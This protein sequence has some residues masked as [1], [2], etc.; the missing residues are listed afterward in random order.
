MGFH[1]RVIAGA[2]ALCFV[3][4]GPA[5]AQL[6]DLGTL[7]G[8]TSQA[9]GVRADGALVVGSSLNASS[10]TQAFVYSVNA[11]FTGGTMTALNFLAGGTAAEARAVNS[12]GLV[13]GYSRDAGSVEQA[14][15]W[16]GTNVAL[17]TNNLGGSGA[18]AFGVSA[19]GDVVGWAR[20]ATGGVQRAFVSVGGGA[21]SALNLS[22]ING[23]HDPSVGHNARA[24]GISPNGRFVV[25]E[26]EV[27]NGSGGIEVR[28][29]VYDQTVPTNSYEFSNGGVGSSRGTNNTQAVGQIV[30]AG[31]TLAGF[32]THATTSAD[33]FPALAGSPGSANAINAAGFSVG[34]ANV[35]GL[36][37]R[38]TLWDQASVAANVSD[39]NDFHSSGSTTLLEANGISDNNIVI[40]SGLFSGLNRAF[41]IAVPEPGSAA[42]VLLALPALGMLRR[43]KHQA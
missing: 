4:M 7:G 36:G 35:S 5:S 23:N 6:L 30:N 3:G 24:L 33:F 9:F 20:Q 14:V 11:G 22:G 34:M 16:T 29:F 37:Q 31:E 19:S 28:G 43:R 26:Y 32:S 38:A 27:D 17:I 42:L 2:L 25:G 40:G 15:T 13:V 8:T 41:L 10:Q 1:G 12:G 18:R 21:M 39:L